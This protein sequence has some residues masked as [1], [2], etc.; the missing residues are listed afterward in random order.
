MLDAESHEPVPSG[1]EGLIYFEPF[2][3][4]VY[5]NDPAKTASTFHGGLVTLGDV[6]YLDPDSYLYL[7][8][9]HS[10]MIVSGGVNIYPRE[11]EET[12][13]AH[14]GVLDVAVFGVPDDEFGE[15]VFAC[16]QPADPDA[17]PAALEFALDA[18]CRE[19]LAGFKRPR[20]YRFDA[21]LPRDANGK[22]YKR[23]LRDE[24]WSSKASRLI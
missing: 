18:H 21:A 5:H 6:G 20:G 13:L 8:D 24:Y 11:V 17:D 4:F 10:D 1:A 9:R 3:N 15:R 2:A 12:L 7:T 19:H 16:V 14:P 23:R 22:L